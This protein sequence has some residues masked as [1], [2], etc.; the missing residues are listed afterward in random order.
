MAQTPQATQ[1]PEAQAPI[2]EAS[3]PI[4]FEEPASLAGLQVAVSDERPEGFVDPAPISD[5]EM[6]KLRAEAERE[7]AKVEFAKK[8]VAARAPKD[9]PP[10]PPPPMAPRM[11]EQTNAEILAGQ[12]AVARHAEH[13][14]KHRPAPVQENTKAVF[15]PG[16]Y[17]PD[18]QKG[19][20]YVQ[21]RSISG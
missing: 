14:A 18:Q 4:N 2:P 21:A 1:A 10:A 17:V 11:V 16:D 5:R 15:R 19:Q 20:G 9:V 13:Y 7:N 12:Q 6:D 3:Q 8:I